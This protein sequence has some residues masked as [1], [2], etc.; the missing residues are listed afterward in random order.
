MFQGLFFSLFLARFFAKMVP[1]YFL[2]F[3]KFTKI[4][5][6]SFECPKSIRNYEKKMPGTSDPW[7]T[8]HSA[9][10]IVDCQ[11]S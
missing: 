2:F 5:T 10:H 7:S 6:K 1:M 4:K 8:S 9:Y 11:I 3:H